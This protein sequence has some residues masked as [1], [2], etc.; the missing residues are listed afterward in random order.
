MFD[1]VGDDALT[2]LAAI[3]DRFVETNGEHPMSGADEAHVRQHFR[4][5]TAEQV[6]DIAAGRRPLPSYLLPDG[7][8]MLADIDECLGAAG[9]ADHLHDWFVAFWPGDPATAEEEWDFFMSGQHVCLRH[10][11]PLSIRRTAVL[12]EQARAA[13]DVLRAD[14][15]DEV[16]QG[17]LGE[18]VDGAVGTVGLDE[19][20]LPTIGHDR[21]RFAMPST[22]DIWVDAV[23][24]EFHH[25]QPPQLPIRTERLTLR[26]ADPAD[27]AGSARAWAD[28]GFV[29]Y[30]L[31]PLK[32]PAEVTFENYQR[33]RPLDP[34]EPHRMLALAIDHEGTAIG[35]VVLF[36]EGA[37]TSCMEIGWTLH[38]WAAGQ[39]LATEAARAMLRLAFEHYG[40]RRVVAN[41]DALNERSAEMCE[42]LGMRRE[43]HRLADFWSKGRWTDSY[44]YALLRSEWEAQ[45]D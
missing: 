20:L 3:R 16:A 15:R 6:A 9:G 17:S 13:V 39:G 29:E 40:V 4:P 19:L 25:P 10:L 44:E 43:V 5:V 34:A 42:R 8:L 14:P 31:N 37:G 18:A 27:A 35:N 26:R 32:N 2:D 36:F 33:T 41:L 11:N 21:R 12:V 7:T 45:Q 30:L 22:R 28:A 38:P 23:R 1:G 24:A